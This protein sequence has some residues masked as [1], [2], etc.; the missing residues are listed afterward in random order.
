MK[1]ETGP[2]KEKKKEKKTSWTESLENSTP[3]FSF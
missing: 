3:N 2:F 1:A